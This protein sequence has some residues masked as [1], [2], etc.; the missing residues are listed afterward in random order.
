MVNFPILYTG[1]GTE[2][3]LKDMGDTYEVFSRKF[4]DAQRMKMEKHL[5]DE[6]FMLEQ[7]VDPVQLIADKAMEKQAADIDWYN[8]EMASRMAKNDGFLSTEDKMWAASNKRK[9]MASQQNWQ[10]NQQRWDYERKLVDRDFGKTWDVDYFRKATED[11]LLTGEFTTGL[12]PIAIDVKAELTEMG[13]RAGTHKETII[14][15]KGGKKV[16]ETVQGY[17]TT[18]E[19]QAAIQ[20]LINR[21]SA[22]G[23]GG[24]KTFINDF[25]KLPIAEQGKWLEDRNKD[26]QISPQEQTNG[27]LR[28]VMNNPDYINAFR[29]EDTSRR[30]EP[31]KPKGSE[32]GFEEFIFG[33]TKVTTLPIPPV[34]KTIG[35]VQYDDYYSILSPKKVEVPLGKTTEIDGNERSEGETYTSEEV[36]F[37]AFSPSKKEF[38]F[39]KARSGGRSDLILSVTVDELNKNYSQ[40]P[41]GLFEWPIVYNNKRMK[42]KDVLAQTGTGVATTSEGKKQIPNF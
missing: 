13:K 21:D 23:G 18:E 31:T 27:I 35:G 24:I 38:F 17:G 19:A 37:I 2:Q 30:T 1:K 3:P 42:I 22:R 25:R 15:E 6:K 8:K 39:R 12:D 16:T 4:M 10:A 34:S 9:I 41:A 33:N 7:G 28:W 5:S 26:G 29:G 11:F 32:F 40:L 14:T 20:E 36:E